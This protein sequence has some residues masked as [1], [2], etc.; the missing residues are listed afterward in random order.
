MCP[1]SVPDPLSALGTSYLL[2]QAIGARMHGSAPWKTEETIV[3]LPRLLVL[4]VFSRSDSP[5][6][7]AVTFDLP[8]LK[9]SISVMIPIPSPHDRPERELFEFFWGGKGE[10]KGASLNSAFLTPKPPASS[11]YM[12]VLEA[13]P[14]L[15][16]SISVMSPC[17]SPLPFSRLNAPGAGP[18]AGLDRFERGMW[19]APRTPPRGGFS[20]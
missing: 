17:P 4:S 2:G 13:P 11:L 8:P 7:V 3:G 1:T 10:G 16:R 9:R 19:V 12:H 20:E 18:T 5:N 14:P 6:L 15:K